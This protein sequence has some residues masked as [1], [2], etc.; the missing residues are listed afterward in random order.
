MLSCFQISYCRNSPTEQEQVVET[1]TA[2]IQMMAKLNHPHIVRIMGATRQG[3]HFNMFNEWMPGMYGLS[4][5]Q[6]TIYG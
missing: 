3:C 6:H 5:N 2:E 1:I 4:T